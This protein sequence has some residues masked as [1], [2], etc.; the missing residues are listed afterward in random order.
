[1]WKVIP[2][3]A[4]HLVTSSAKHIL[5][6][7]GRNG[8]IQSRENVVPPLP[9]SGWASAGIVC[10]VS[11]PPVTKMLRNKRGFPS[12]TAKVFWDLGHITYE[13]R[14]RT[15]GI[16]FVLQREDYRAI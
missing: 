6:Y 11:G 14:L 9:G 2:K 15:V 8:A 16:S 13:D 1:M 3:C 7:I 5:G 10:P 12:R 4:V